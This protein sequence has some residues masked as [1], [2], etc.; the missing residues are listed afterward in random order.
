[1]QFRILEDLE[2]SF[3]G[4]FRREK[5]RSHPSGFLPEKGGRDGS[6]QLQLYPQGSSLQSIKHSKAGNVNSLRGS[7]FILSVPKRTKGNRNPSDNGLRSAIMSALSPLG[8]IS[9]PDQPFSR[10]PSACMA[11]M[12]HYSYTWQNCVRTRIILP[13]STF[14]S[15]MSV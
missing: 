1:M 10:P 12:L 3:P 15:I 11:T 2:I 9:C 5:R 6:Q 13:H 7:F 4:G 14:A 8:P